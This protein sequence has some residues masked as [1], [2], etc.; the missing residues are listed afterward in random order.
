MDEKSLKATHVSHHHCFAFDHAVLGM[1]S[2]LVS[3]HGLN[4][5]VM[6]SKSFIYGRLK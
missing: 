1:D 4:C 5:C 6:H 3:K 2:I